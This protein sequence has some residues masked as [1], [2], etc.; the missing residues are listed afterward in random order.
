MFTVNALLIGIAGAAWAWS[1]ADMLDRRFYP[2]VSRA[3]IFAVGGLTMLL[4]VF[5]YIDAAPA[6]TCPAPAGVWL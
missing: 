6:A 4:V 5:D 2:A 1:M 3:F